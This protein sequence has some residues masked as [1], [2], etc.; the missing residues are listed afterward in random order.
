LRSKPLD[1]AA[2]LAS[3]GRTDGAHLRYRLWLLKDYFEGVLVQNSLC[4]LL[5]FRSAN[6]PK[7]LEITALV[8]FSTATP[9]ISNYQPTL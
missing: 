3:W 5:N 7:F 2:R 8:L 6:T 4:N 9:V 1:G